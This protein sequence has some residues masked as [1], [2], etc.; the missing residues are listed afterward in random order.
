MLALLEKRPGLNSPKT[1]HPSPF[2]SSAW[3]GEG[4]EL[5]SYFIHFCRNEFL[6]PFFSCIFGPINFISG[7]L[8]GVLSSGQLFLHLIYFLSLCPTADRSNRQELKEIKPIFFLFT[9]C[10]WQNFVSIQPY[11]F[12]SAIIWLLP[13]C[14]AIIEAERRKHLKPRGIIL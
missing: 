11:C 5:R 9:L 8:S 12:L 10:V 2:I 3:L 1:S 14:A 6:I 7:S 4:T 13:I